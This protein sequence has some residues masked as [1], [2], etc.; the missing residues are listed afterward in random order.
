[1]LRQAD[2]QDLSLKFMYSVNFHNT[3]L[4]MHQSLA[5][6]PSIKGCSSKAYVI[7]SPLRVKVIYNESE[8]ATTQHCKANQQINGSS[9]GE[10]A[11]HPVFHCSSAFLKAVFQFLRGVDNMMQS[12]IVSKI[13]TLRL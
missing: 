1:V 5:P 13:F 8:Q 12:Q 7:N 11:F 10:Q 6:C 2:V 4:F 9:A 3:I